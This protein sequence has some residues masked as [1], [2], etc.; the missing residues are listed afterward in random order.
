MER[1]KKHINVTIRPS[2]FQHL[3]EVRKQE[4]KSRSEVVDTA[5][6]TW[7]K[8]RDE[9]LMAEGA[10]QQAAESEKIAQ[11]SMKMASRV[12]ID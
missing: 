9:Q 12:D 7:L 4:G 6:E 1:Q 8:I 11:A 3:E 2:T 5:I 10:R